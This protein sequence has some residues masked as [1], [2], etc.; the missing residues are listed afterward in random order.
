MAPSL[1]TDTLLISTELFVLHS[2]LK[3]GFPILSESVLFRLESLPVISLVIVL[4]HLLLQSTS[5]GGAS[6]IH[7]QVAGF[8]VLSTLL[9]L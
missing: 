2:S 4:S 1:L 6:L 3:A 8:H 9:E 7:H 5:R